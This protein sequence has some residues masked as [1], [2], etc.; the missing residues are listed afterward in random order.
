MSKP[1][2]IAISESAGAAAESSPSLAEAG[3]HT[4]NGRHALWQEALG[5][6]MD[7]PRW[8]FHS[9]EMPDGQRFIALFFGQE[10]AEIE[11]VVPEE[12]AGR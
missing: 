4:E 6:E 1:Y 8:G 3:A 2:R 5:C 11:L 10:L 12:D 7:L 9:F